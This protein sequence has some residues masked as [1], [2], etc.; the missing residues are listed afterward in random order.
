MIID[1]NCILLVK[2]LYV[3]FLHEKEIFI[4]HSEKILLETQALVPILS[5]FTFED[6]L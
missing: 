1:D 6:F 3:K 4:L 2:V 5:L